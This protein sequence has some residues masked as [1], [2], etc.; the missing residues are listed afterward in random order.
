MEGDQQIE[1]IQ[2]DD[3]F[4]SAIE[5]TEIQK[6][7]LTC[8]VKISENLG[9]YELKFH[10]EG[11]V[12]VQC[13]RCLDDM[14]LPIVADNRLNVKFGEENVDDGDDLIVVSEEEG[15]LDLAWYIYEFIVLALP[16][17]HMH[18]LGECNEKMY[19]E[20]SKHLVSAKDFDEESEYDE[21]DT[22]EELSENTVTDP[23]WEKLK[24]AFM[25][26]GSTEI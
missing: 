6:G 5:A 21:S 12:I 14:Q 22:D 23:R 8:A 3:H 15:T 20:Y 9:G 1:T 13:D 4:F 7:S 26:K 10:T 16:I 25:S 2:L 19:E 24:D 17:Q 18:K 11:F